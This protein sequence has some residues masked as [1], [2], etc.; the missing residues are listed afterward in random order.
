MPNK[1]INEV[2]FVRRYEHAFKD[3]KTNRW[4]IEN[5][6]TTLGESDYI[7]EVNSEL[8]NT[9]LEENKEIARL[10]KR[11]LF[12]ISN[13]L[14]IKDSEN[15]ENNGKVFKFKFGQK[16]FDK[17]VAATKPDE[18]LGEQAINPF[19]PHTGANFSIKQKK[20]MNFPN[21]DES[22]FGSSQPLCGGKEKE[23]SEILSQCY[24]LSLEIA[25]EKF[26]SYADLKKRFLFVIGQEESTKG[27]PTQGRVNQASQDD[28]D[29]GDA[30]L[31]K[32]AE[33]ASTPPKKSG[34]PLPVM[35]SG[36]GDD[37]DAAFFKSLID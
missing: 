9:Q 29:A 13:I 27:K 32:L 36:A 23:M 16:I 2:P 17:I 14:V 3:P 15:P 31:S 1:D 21:Y 8:W 12:Y 22:K 6:L 26:K 30:E 35:D 25:P 37:D 11:K 28:F 19:D 24:D 33:M 7:S 18:S 5:S 4:Y 20:V 10:R 34:P